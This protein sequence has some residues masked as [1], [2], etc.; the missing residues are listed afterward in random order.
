M[1][2]FIYGNKQIEYKL[3]ES[4]RRKTL[5]ISVGGDGIVVTSPE[6]TPQKKIEQVLNQK[7]PWILKQ[8][9]DFEEMKI[10][11]KPKAFV[12]GEKLPYLGRKLF[13]TQHDGFHS[14]SRYISCCCINNLSN[15]LISRKS[16]YR[17]TCRNRNLHGVI[18]SAA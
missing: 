10:Q 17:E 4:N 12:A 7:A 9:S 1:N 11:I 2:T 16:V 8:L 15:T 18:P 3:Q 14:N 13:S 6:D 5:S